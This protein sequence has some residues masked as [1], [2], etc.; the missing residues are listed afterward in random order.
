LK[1]KAMQFKE[2]ETVSC[3]ILVIGGGG[4]GLRAAV[5][6]R[7]RGADVLVV[8]KSRVGYGNNTYISKAALSATGWG[9]P[10]DG[11]EV[12]LKDTVI[13]GRFL[14]DQTLVIAN[15]LLGEMRRHFFKKGGQDSA[16]TC[17]RP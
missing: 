1:R 12:H 8:S 3:D 7:E 17:S 16:R 2:S 11:P 15:S 14:N 4:T 13:G 5:E 10:K 6:A 9:D